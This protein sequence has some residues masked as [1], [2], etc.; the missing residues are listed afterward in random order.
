MPR[1]RLP[2]PA[3]VSSRTHE[4]L[5]RL[6]AQF[7]S[8]ARQA[9]EEL[10]AKFPM[11]PLEQRPQVVAGFARLYT[12]TGDPFYAWQA[13]RCAQQWSCSVPPAVA[14]YVG[15][16]AKGMVDIA[17]AEPEQLT[18]AA[19]LSALEMSGRGRRAVL[20]KRRQ[21]A[22]AAQ[23]AADVV[24]LRSRGH[25]ETNAIAL[26]AQ[27]HKVAATSVGDAYRKVKALGRNFGSLSGWLRPS[28]GLPD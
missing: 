22:R 1:S 24:A 2:V 17:I 23:Y 20:A 25:K 11:P 5:K 28:T 7:G 19:L 12:D 8:R 14:A 4:S 10:R 16:V 26:V 6:A 9:I 15:R 3:E 18:R 21:R 13:Y 27:F